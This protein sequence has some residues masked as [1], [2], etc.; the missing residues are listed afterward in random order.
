[1]WCLGQN[2]RLTSEQFPD[3]VRERA[4]AYWSIRLA[5]AENSSSPDKFREELSA[6]GQ[7][8][9]YEQIGASWLLDQLSKMLRAGYVSDNPYSILDWL[10]TICPLHVDR[11]VDVLSALLTSNLK[12][13]YIYFT[14]PDAIR[15]VLTQGKARGVPR[16]LERV[17]HLVSYLASHG[18]TAY[19]DL[20]S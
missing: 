16:T 14:Q 19:L 3:T 2:L 18:V 1:M 17:D 5:A 8:C 13:K 6:I 10:S 15:N 9:S 7:W 4:L 11:A 20:S 12:D